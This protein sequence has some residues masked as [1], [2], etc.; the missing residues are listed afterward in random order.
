M[1]FADRVQTCPGP[2]DRRTRK[3]STKRRGHFGPTVARGIP[4]SVAAILLLIPFL[5]NAIAYSHEPQGPSGDSLKRLVNRTRSQ[6]FR[7]M[8][9]EEHS[10]LTL[11]RHGQ[12]DS[13]SVLG[14]WSVATSKGNTLPQGRWFLG[15]LEGRL[16]MPI[17]P[18]WALSIESQAE[19]ARNEPTKL[20]LGAPTLQRRR[21]APHDATNDATNETHTFVRIGGSFDVDDTWLMAYSPT[22]VHVEPAG[23]WLATI[24]EDSIVLPKQEIVRWL[25]PFR[26]LV[27]FRYRTDAVVLMSSG[28]GKPCLIWRVDARDGRVLWQNVCWALRPPLSRRRLSLT[29]GSAFD[30]FEIVHNRRQ[31]SVFGDGVAGSYIDCFDWDTGVATLRFSTLLW[32]PPS[33]V[34]DE[35]EAAELPQTLK[36]TSKEEE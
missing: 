26:Y 19:K 10:D 18:Q 25:T 34:D 29:S 22:T 5:S 6:A 28:T 11:A 27:V 15:F 35:D 23:E 14:A 7:T 12:N 9:L 1:N 8:V 21:F 30:S 31:V 4:S 24:G 16:G 33:T 20:D 3:P 2:V 32:K 13:I 36:S 17:P